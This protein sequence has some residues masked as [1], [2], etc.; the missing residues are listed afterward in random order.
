MRLS[1]KDFDAL[2]HAILELY[3][4][5]TLEAFRQASVEIARSIIPSDYSLWGVYALGAVPKLTNSKESYRCLTPAMIAYAEHHLYSHPFSLYFLRTGDV[6]ALKLSDFLS[7][8]QLKN[9]RMWEEYYR[10][11]D[12][13]YMLC[14]STTTGTANVSA[15]GVSRKSRDFTERD[16]LILNL[17]RPHLLQ[18]ARLA[19]R[20]GDQRN[21]QGCTGSVEELHD[22]YGLSPR[23]CE[24]AHWVAE[25]KTNPEIALILSASPRTIEKHM[26]KILE[27]LGVENRTSAA[28][29]LIKFL[30]PPTIRA[31]R[32]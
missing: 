18:A 24:V 28:A 31:V 25:G 12:A 26:E 20:I 2:Q 27:K 29:V 10:P 16:R 17:L 21:R 1:H 6:S 11:M 13:N 5:R 32:S 19:E 23:E 8:H 9:S 22:T 3:E 30:P 14:A 4:L 15:I 7:L